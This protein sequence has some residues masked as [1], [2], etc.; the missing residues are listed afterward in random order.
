MK[1]CE[2]HMCSFLV[3]PYYRLTLSGPR[4]YMKI[5]K[6]YILSKYELR[7][8]RP[9]GGLLLR[10]RTLAWTPGPAKF[11]RLD[12]A[13][14]EEQCSVGFSSGTPNE[15]EVMVGYKESLVEATLKPQVW[16][17]YVIPADE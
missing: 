10:R 6:A 4:A 1:S 9:C 11:S 13:N 8:G 3:N 16:A 12:I 14:I 5:L 2:A 7:T 15:A 17:I